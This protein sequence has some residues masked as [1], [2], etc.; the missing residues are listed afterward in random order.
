MNGQVGFF[1]AL[2][3]TC[4]GTGIFSRLCRNS[5][6]RTLLHLFLLS[7]FC[8]FA[9]TLVRTLRIAPEIKGFAA[10]FFDTFGNLKFNAYGLRPEKHPDEARTYAVSGG[11]WVSYF[12]SAPDG[13]SIP[14]EELLLTTL[15]VVW[16]PKQLIVLAPLGE[17]VW[18]C[19]VFPLYGSFP[20]R[21]DC[22]IAELRSFLSGLRELPGKIPMMP[23]TETVW[24]RRFVMTN[25]CVV[26][27][28]MFLLSHFLT[29]FLLPLF[30]TGVFA[31]LFRFTG[32]RSLRSMTLGT[33][34]KIGMYAGFPVMLFAS[35]F[36]AFDLPFL[37]YSTV[38]MFGLVMYW[39]AAAGRVERDGKESGGRKPDE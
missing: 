29:A 26:M 9:V 32:G 37:S 23:E 31:L 19:N 10:G 21:R 30:Y 25:V 27:A 15:G 36:P 4:S 16:T 17:G 13:V 20:L 5:W 6:R 24:T 38:Y 33:F 11:R 18:C 8:S 39:L 34:W 2:L 22:S 14:E 12:P 1:S 28:A 7:V 35:C 3:G